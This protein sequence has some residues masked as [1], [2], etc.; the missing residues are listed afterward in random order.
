MIEENKSVRDL[1]TFGI[2]AKTRWF[3]EYASEAA[4][5][6]VLSAVRTEWNRGHACGELKVLHIGGGSNLLFLN[7]YDGLMLHS[8]IR[9]I[10]VLE[11]NENYVCIRVGAGMVW[12]DLVAE[13]IERGWYGLE[14]LTAIPGEVGAA[15]VQNIGAYGAEAKDYIT[16]VHLL[17][18]RTCEV[19]SMSREEMKYAYRYSALKSAELWGRYAVTY[20][21]LLLSK[22]FQPRLDYGGLRTALDKQGIKEESLTAS[23]LR[24]IIREVRD[25]KL[26]DPKVLG[27]AGSFFM[28]PVVE[29]PVYDALYTE[30]PDMP[31]YDVDETHVKI[32]AGWL[33]DKAGWKGRS[34]GRAAV[35]DRQA[36]VLVNLGGA[37]GQDIVALCE[38][39]RA[40]VKDKFGITIKPEVNFIG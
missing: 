23:Q 18:M 11:E 12:D 31:H 13:T 2:E 3:A 40:D 29:R 37:S 8:A 16:R 24:T 22:Q 5:V 17:D 39:V 25:A 7:D 34:M 15:A 6:D 19:C 9:G 28:N 30:Y 21:E 14:N 1:N 35:Y 4:L 38:A 27:N 26:P 10:E 36:L 33:I 20:V 32:P